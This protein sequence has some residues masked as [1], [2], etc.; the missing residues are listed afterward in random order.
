MQPNACSIKKIKDDMTL[1]QSGA[2]RESPRQRNEL[3]LEILEIIGPA[4]RVG[5]LSGTSKALIGRNLP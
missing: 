3:P 5:G 4:L 2:D 1:P